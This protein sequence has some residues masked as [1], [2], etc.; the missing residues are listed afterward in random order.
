MNN[1]IKD[2]L[3]LIEDHIE[4]TNLLIKNNF[5]EKISLLKEFYPDKNIN[6]KELS[7]LSYKES[8]LFSNIKL[9][10]LK[11]QRGYDFNKKV[12]YTL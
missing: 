8:E 6:K 1:E 9:F 11:V 7:S 10:G 4:K 5:Y 2:S 12:I 3:K